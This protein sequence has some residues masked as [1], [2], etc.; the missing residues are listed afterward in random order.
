MA[1]WISRI[2]WGMTGIYLISAAWT[3]QRTKTIPLK[4]IGIYGILTGTGRLVLFLLGQNPG[5][6]ELLMSMM[7]G[8]VLLMLGLV[9]RQ[10]VGYG[11]G[12]SLLFGGI[13]LGASSICAIS[14]T[15]FALCAVWG[16][17]RIIWKKASLQEELAFLPFL[18]AGYFLELGGYLLEQFW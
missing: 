4:Q 12:L 8:A 3:D 6:P 2:L 1:I 11:D 9:T 18:T 14:L 17:W 16:I 13:A 10:A 7:P 15:G 5:I